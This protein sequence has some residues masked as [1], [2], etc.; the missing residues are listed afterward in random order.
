[1]SRFLK[2]C[3]RNQLNY[4]TATNSVRNVRTVRGNEQAA[5]ATRTEIVPD[6]EVEDFTRVEGFFEKV[7]HDIELKQNRGRLFAICHLYGHQHMFTEGDYILLKKHF[8][9][10]SGTKIK[11]EKVMMVGGENLTLIG[12]PVLDR[13][14]VHVEATLVEKTLSHTITNVLHVPRQSNYQRW[15][16]QRF[17]LSTLR[18]NEIKICHKINDTQQELQ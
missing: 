4:I 12:R 10:G 11:F 8:P 14:L 17:A 13:D 3:S 1:M 9:A 2:L 7:N 5:S 16:F 18:I 15:R 6:T